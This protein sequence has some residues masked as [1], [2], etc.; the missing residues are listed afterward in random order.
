MALGQLSTRSVGKKTTC[1]AGGV[2]QA[3]SKKP[4]DA[5]VIIKLFKLLWL[6]NLSS[7]SAREGP[8]IKSGYGRS[9]G[10]FVVFSIQKMTKCDMM[11]ETK[12]DS[13]VS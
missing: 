4:P 12:P 7:E 11:E 6:R 10:L 1:Y 3:Y 13:T 8:V 5:N 2:V 9:L